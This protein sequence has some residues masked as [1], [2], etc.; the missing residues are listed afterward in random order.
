MTRKPALAAA[1]VAAH[2][3][4]TELRSCGFQNS[5]HA[6]SYNSFDRGYQAWIESR[7]TWRASAMQSRRLA[8]IRAALDWACREF[9][10]AVPYEMDAAVEQGVW[11]NH[12]V[13]DVLKAELPHLV[14]VPRRAQARN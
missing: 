9:G 11:A 6:W 8:L 14:A 4:V 2:A 3:D 7:P 12:S 13:R 10:L 5:Y 1:I